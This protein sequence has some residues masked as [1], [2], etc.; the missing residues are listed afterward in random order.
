MIK[1]VTT[2]GILNLSKAETKFQKTDNTARSIID[3]ETTARDKKTARLRA[4]RLA[5]EALEHEPPAKTVKK[6]AGVRAAKR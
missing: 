1:T 2:P 5:R 4:A 6:T 3:A